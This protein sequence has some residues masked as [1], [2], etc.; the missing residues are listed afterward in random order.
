VLPAN[1]TY[2]IFTP[3]TAAR[4]PARHHRQV[5]LAGGAHTAIRRGSPALFRILDVAA[6]A[7]LSPHSVSILDGRTSGLAAAF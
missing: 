6:G 4:W 7:S 2:D 1:C 5:A 3:V